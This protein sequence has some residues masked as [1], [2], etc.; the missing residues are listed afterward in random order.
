[1]RRCF[2]SDSRCRGF[3]GAL[4]LI[5]S[6]TDETQSAIYHAL[7]NCFADLASRFDLEALANVDDA[8]WAVLPYVFPKLV[9][10]RLLFGIQ[11]ATL[12]K[13]E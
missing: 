1:M 10:E 7:V 9:I 8:E 5:F 4:G 2:T 11:R 12:Q 13:R 3:G 6:V